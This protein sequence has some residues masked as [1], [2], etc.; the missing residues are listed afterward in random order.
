M[1]VYTAA[2]LQNLAQDDAD[3]VAQF[4]RISTTEGQR[5]GSGNGEL[6]D[7]FLPIRKTGVDRASST[8]PPRTSRTP[9]RRREEP[10][11]RADAP[12]PTDDS[13]AARRR[14]RLRRRRP[15][16][17]PGGGEPVGRAEPVGDAVGAA[18]A[19]DP[20]AG[21]PGGRLR[22]R[23]RP[24]A[25]ADPARRRSAAS[26]H[27]APAS[28]RRRP[29][30]SMTATMDHDARAR[31]PPSRPSARRPRRAGA[32]PRTPPATRPRARPA[33]PTTPWRCCR[34]RSR[35]SPSSASGWSR[36]CCS[37]AAISQDRAQD[38]LY[39]EFRDEL[40][41]ATAPDRA[42]SSR[43][44]DPVA[45]L[46]DPAARASSRSSSRAPRPATLLAGP[47]HRR[48][49][50]LP[51][52]V[53][54]SV[55]YGRATTYGGPF[56]RPDPAPGRRRDRGRRSAQ[57]AGGFKVVGVRRAGDPLPQPLADGRRPADAGHRRGQRS[58]RRARPGLGG[59]RRRRRQEGVPRTVRPTRRRCPIRAV[60][61]R[62][63]G[64]TAAPGP[65]A[66]PCSWR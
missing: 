51:G 25:A 27:R 15:A 30:T 35:W 65:A 50:P 53:G 4:I 48:D 66:W 52:Q 58:P 24:A 10:R 17:C 59:L 5:P 18:A 56:A 1:V 21:H 22:P 39:H 46:S 40:A 33:R 3:K 32:A 61:G 28:A 13:D 57:G 6:P 47:G 14:R 55:V 41:G 20:D 37:S 38:L 19:A 31:T 29:G 42:R 60:D 8:T 7:G 36:S 34:R 26:P 49:T 45:L 16:T 64:R 2:R 23:R 12:A 44:G 43:S 11:R 63:H 54:T 9:S 62:G